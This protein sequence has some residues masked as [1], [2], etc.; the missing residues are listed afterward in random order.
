M[1]VPAWLL[2]LGALG[3]GY[4]IFG[5]KKAS[6]QPKAKTAPS[7]KPI[8]PVMPSTAKVDLQPVPLTSKPIDSDIR[9]KM[10]K[11]GNVE[12]STSPSGA[13]TFRKPDG[14]NI[15][16]LPTVDVIAGKASNSAFV[17]TVRDPLNIRSKPDSN[18]PKVSTA[19]KGSVLQIIG[20]IVAGP[21]SKKGWAPVQKPGTTIVGYA[22]VD[23]LSDIDIDPA[24]QGP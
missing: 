19:A 11:E 15:T 1:A 24:F 22:A 7:P 9:D 23:Y 6:A 16:V 10:I 12:I 3:A 8:D 18:S 20:K 13:V 21:G 14:G 2:G 5:E 17:N 4:L